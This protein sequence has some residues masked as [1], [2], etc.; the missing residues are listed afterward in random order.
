[1]NQTIILQGH[2]PTVRASRA[3]RAII[4]RKMCARAISLAR[5]KSLILAIISTGV[6]YAGALTGSDLTMYSGAFAALLAVR[7][8]TEK[9]G[10]A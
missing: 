4:V 9:G 1:M 3:L 8:M 5:R 10:E 6:C 7:P 2:A